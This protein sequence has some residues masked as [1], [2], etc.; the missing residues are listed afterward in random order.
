ME[1]NALALPCL[2]KFVDILGREEV[3]QC[4][5]HFAVLTAWL[6]RSVAQLIAMGR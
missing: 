3:G 5:S 6:E 1:T 4:D 2:Y